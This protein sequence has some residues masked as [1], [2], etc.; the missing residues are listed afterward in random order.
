MAEEEEEFEV[1]PA[2]VAHRLLVS[3]PPLQFPAVLDDLKDLLE[4]ENVMPDV[5]PKA[6]KEYNLAQ[7]V[8][9]NSDDGKFLVTKFNE[10]GTD[11]YVDP[12]HGKV[13]TVDHTEQKVLSSEDW[14]DS[15]SLSETRKILD[16]LMKDYVKDNY[17]NATYGVFSSEGKIVVCISTAEFNKNSFWSGRW[18]STCEC[19]LGGDEVDMTGKIETNCHIYEAGNVMADGVYE[20]SS[21]IGGGSDEA[22]ANGIFEAIKAKEI[23]YQEK[24][25]EAMTADAE[26][27]FKKLRRKLPI[28]G[29]K[30]PWEKTAVATLARDITNK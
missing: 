14:E 4:G 24:S 2:Q 13:H 20:W 21:S 5:T 8:A 29:N 3:S 7:M 17:P 12:T 26:K 1:D 10:T 15:S 27:K 30:F 6:R 11:T 9:I 28:H 23:S 18:R 19:K 22:A 25:N 16:D